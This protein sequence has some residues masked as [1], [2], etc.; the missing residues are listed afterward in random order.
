[1]C[2]L[3]HQRYHYIRIRIRMLQ[4][5]SNNAEPTL[6]FETTIEL[7]PLNAQNFTVAF[8]T[9]PAFSSR[10]ISA[11]VL[12][13]SLLRFVHRDR[14][15]FA[16]RRQLFSHFPTW[17]ICATTLLHQPLVSDTSNNKGSVRFPNSQLTHCA[18][19]VLFKPAQYHYAEHSTIRLCAFTM[20]QSPTGNIGN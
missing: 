6:S 8:T 4:L 20:P 13:Y 10:R 3:S 19:I 14:C 18:S 17:C 2:N 12:Y 16:K 9:A 1:M 15:P 11:I 5:E 7:R